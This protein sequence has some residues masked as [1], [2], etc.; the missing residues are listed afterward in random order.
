MHSNFSSFA[1]SLL[2][3]SKPQHTL[4]MLV[5]LVKPWLFLHPVHTGTDRYER[6]GQKTKPCNYYINRAIIFDTG[7]FASFQNRQSTIMELNISMKFCSE[8]ES[9]K[10]QYKEN[11]EKRAL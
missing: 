7:V 8:A 11:Q 10:K 3:K 5:F 6:E 2:Y 9:M 4:Q 1:L